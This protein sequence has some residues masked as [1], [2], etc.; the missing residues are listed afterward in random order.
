MKKLNLKNTGISNLVFK[1]LINDRPRLF[2]ILWST[3]FQETG[4][5][6]ASIVCY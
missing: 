2:A 5:P 3:D 6:C 1:N 4:N